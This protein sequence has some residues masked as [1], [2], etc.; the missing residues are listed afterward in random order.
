MTAEHKDMVTCARAT[1]KGKALEAGEWSSPFILSPCRKMAPASVHR[2]QFREREDRWSYHFASLSENFRAQGKRPMEQG[3]IYVTPSSG[4]LELHLS[5]G[6]ITCDEKPLRDWILQPPLHIESSDWAQWAG[7]NSVNK[8]FPEYL[9][10]A[11]NCCWQ[12]D[13][14][15]SH[16]HTGSPVHSLR[17]VID[18]CTSNT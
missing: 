9:L 12:R 4:D 2:S 17:E 1:A 3:N 7:L 18:K 10:L 15:V 5:R 16:T 6:S 11:K 8:V 13:R 14:T